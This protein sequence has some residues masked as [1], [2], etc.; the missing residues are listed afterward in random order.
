M[1]CRDIA[2]IARIT[3]NVCQGVGLF[4]SSGFRMGAPEAHNALVGE[5]RKRKNEDSK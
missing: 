3:A 4:A 2:G 1:L 5:L